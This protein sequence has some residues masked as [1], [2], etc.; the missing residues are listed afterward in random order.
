MVKKD[1]SDY[2]VD[3]VRRVVD[4]IRELGDRAATLGISENYLSALRAILERLQ[5]SPLDWG[6]PEW[7][8]KRKG[9]YVCHG[10]LPPLVVH[11]VVFEPERVVCILNIKPLPGSPLA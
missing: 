11:Y 8:T 9:G 6:D 3:R 1:E 4:Q 10:I 7:R 5:T 2:R